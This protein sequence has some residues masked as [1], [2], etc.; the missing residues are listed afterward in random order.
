MLNLLLQ[1]T[2]V[3]YGMPFFKDSHENLDVTFPMKL[4]V[5][6]E[7]LI[8]K[9]YIIILFLYCL[10]LECQRSSCINSYHGLEA[11]HKLKL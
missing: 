8:F 11:V 2:S 6:L 3:S 4:Y 7:L 10:Q 9:S 1:K 5:D